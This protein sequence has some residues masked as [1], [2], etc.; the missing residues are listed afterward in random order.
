VNRILKL[1]ILAAVVVLIAIGT[2]TVTVFNPSP[3]GTSSDLL[4][5]FCSTISK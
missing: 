2:F 1:A 5:Q 4:P 3:S